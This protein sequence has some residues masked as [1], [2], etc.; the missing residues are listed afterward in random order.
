MQAIQLHRQAH[1]DYRRFSVMVGCGVLFMKVGWRTAMK[2]SPHWRTCTHLFVCGASLLEK[3]QGKYEQTIQIRDDRAMLATVQS[4][5]K[6]STRTGDQRQY[7]LHV[8]RHEREFHILTHGVRG[9]RSL[10]RTTR[11]FE[12]G[13]RD[14]TDHAQADGR[15]GARREHRLDCPVWVSLERHPGVLH[16]V[17][18]TDAPRV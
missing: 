12:P 8:R 10:R 17:V 15:I 2:C 4:I 5:S 18:R 7:L 9:Q 11:S 1:A 16:G 14:S 3:R 13:T 6:W